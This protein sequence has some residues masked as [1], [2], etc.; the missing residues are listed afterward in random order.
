[1]PPILRIC[2]GL[3]LLVAIRFEAPAQTATGSAR[4]I[5]TAEPAPT[6]I[7]TQRARYMAAHDSVRRLM[8]GIHLLAESRM[9][10]FKATQSGMNRSRRRVRGF[11]VPP[12]MKINEV[13]TKNTAGGS[14]IKDQIIK[15]NFGTEREKVVYYDTRHR[16]VLTERY[17]NHQLVRLELAEY[18]DI[19][20]VPFSQWLLVRG[21][22]LRH[23]TQRMQAQAPR[24][25]FF[26]FNTA[27]AA[28]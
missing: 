28:E 23:N 6:E 10:F 19:I 18:T 2:A 5:A 24:K 3:S 17:E 14:I 9:R 21:G 26:Y 15:R 13:G 1:M 12:S 25:S 20:S 16:K 22:Y 4:V 11:A 7:A 27:P 8:E